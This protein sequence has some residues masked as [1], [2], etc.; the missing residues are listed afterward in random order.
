MC[1]LTKSIC[2]MLVLLL[3]LPCFVGTCMASEQTYQIS[4][5]ELTG[6]QTNLNKLEQN[7]KILLQDSTTSAKQLIE[8]LN[9]IEELK[10][11]IQEQKQLLEKS[12]QEISMTQQSLA[13]A[14]NSLVT[15]NELFK[16]YAKEEQSKQAQLRIERDIA[17]AA[18]IYFAFKK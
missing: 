1:K 17:I 13:K 14:E 16:K 10:Q 11:L 6:L 12:K 5:N 7:Y 4:E 15:A 3:L 8:A 2:C 9:S 18:A